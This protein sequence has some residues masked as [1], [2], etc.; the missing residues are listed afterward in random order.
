FLFSVSANN[1][2]TL[3]IFSMKDKRASVFAEIQGGF[4]AKGL[5]SPDGRWVAYQALESGET[6]IYVEPFPQTGAKYRVPQDGNNHHPVWSQPNGNEL[7][8]VPGNGKLDSVSFT[9][10]PSPAFG[11][12]VPMPKGSGFDTRE[13]SAIRSYDIL[14]N[15]KQFVGTVAAARAQS[16]DG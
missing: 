14:P 2:N 1:T 12:P 3:W 6:R 11:P 15:G 7:F 10:K 4:T 13:P 8:F 5:F 16:G 9:I